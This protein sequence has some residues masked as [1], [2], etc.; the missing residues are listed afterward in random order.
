MMASEKA[1]MAK[2]QREW[3]ARD[4]LDTLKH[5][6]EIA[7]DRTRLVAAEREAKKQIK[8]LARVAGKK[9][10]KKSK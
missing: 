3:R 1:R 8:A 9:K 5:A 4:D 10:A 2:E 6:E 7:N